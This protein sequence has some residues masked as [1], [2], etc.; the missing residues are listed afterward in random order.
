MTFFRRRLIS[1]TPYSTMTGYVDEWDRITVK[2]KGLWRPRLYTL[3]DSFARQSCTSAHKTRASRLTQIRLCLRT[4]SLKDRRVTSQACVD[5][6]A[7]RT[8]R[9]DVA[10]FSPHLCPLLELAKPAIVTT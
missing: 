5:D 10:G 1:T 2:A 8:F 7:G 6:G 9:R 3:I 4:E